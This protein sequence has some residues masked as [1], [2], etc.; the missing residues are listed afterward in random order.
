MGWRTVV[1][2][3]PSKIDLRLGY[4]VIRDVDSTVRVA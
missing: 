4:A 2:S 3:K 1:V